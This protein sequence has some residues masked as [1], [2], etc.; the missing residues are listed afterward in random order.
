[1][2]YREVCGFESHF[3]HHGRGSSARQTTLMT[4]LTIA[5]MMR[6][7]VRL[8]TRRRCSRNTRGV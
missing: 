1:M 3:G 2:Q 5:L 8:I 4:A 7:V 6:R